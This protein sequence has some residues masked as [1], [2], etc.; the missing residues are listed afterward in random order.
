ME[1][2]HKPFEAKRTRKKD[3]GEAHAG[4]RNPKAFGFANSGTTQRKVQRS[5]DVSRI[6][7]IEK[8]LWL[9]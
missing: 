3:G 9:I 6:L 7:Q 4:G 5:E 2:V 8:R 1:K